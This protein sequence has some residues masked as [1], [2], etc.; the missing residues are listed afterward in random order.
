MSEYSDEMKARF[1]SEEVVIPLEIDLGHSPDGR[2]LLLYIRFSPSD[3]LTLAL[4]LPFAR[5]HV[6]LL[7][8]LV[9][10]LEHRTSD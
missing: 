9:S 1:R 6:D 10:E 7:E 4:P 8:K 2:F 3:A 5:R